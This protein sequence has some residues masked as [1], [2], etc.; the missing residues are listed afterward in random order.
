VLPFGAVLAARLLARRLDAARL[1]PALLI[2]LTGYLACVSR[3]MAQPAQPARG[4]QLADWLAAHRLDYGLAGYWQ[5]ACT[6]LASDG[7]VQ[8]V[9]VQSGQE[10][11]S[12]G[13]WE[14]N[15]AWYDPLRHMA[16]FVV[17]PPGAPGIGYPW[18]FDVRAAFGQPA[19]IYN[20][21]PYTVLVWNRNLL[22]GLR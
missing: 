4:Q 18:S 19:R 7:R 11:V 2:A 5:A 21:G 20:A 22:A 9:P 16:T 12:R 14:T 17:L 1:T 6:T 3:E 15:A 8:V 13:G 10:T